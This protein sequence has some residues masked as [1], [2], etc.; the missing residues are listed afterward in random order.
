MIRDKLSSAGVVFPEDIDPRIVTL[1]S[2][3]VFRVNDGPPY[4]RV[5][6]H[7][8]ENN[9]VGVTIPILIPRGLALLGMA[10]G[11]QATIHGPDHPDR[12]L[13]DKVAFQPE[14]ARRALAEGASPDR[15]PP[16]VHSGPPHAR[17]T[18]SASGSGVV[19]LAAQRSV[20]NPAKLR[21]GPAGNGGPGPSAA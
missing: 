20:R 16:E 15:R 5:V 8:R 19:D 3:I 10:E 21:G 2:R 11:Q 7:A 14:A 9:L 1:N 12:I 17:D 4:T 6:V 13:V 18:A